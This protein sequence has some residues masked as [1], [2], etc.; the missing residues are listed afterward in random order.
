MSDFNGKH[1]FPLYIKEDD[2]AAV[3]SMYREYGCASQSE[4]IEKAVEFYLGYLKMDMDMDLIAPVVMSTIRSVVTENT[5][6][7]TRLLFK[8]SVEMALMNNILAYEY[9]IDPENVKKVREEC[10]KT[11][12]KTNG[13]FMLEDAINWQRG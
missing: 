13:N 4:F 3:K 8:N 1:R 2:L 5:T 11:V 6:R 10:E 12:R 7:I 9:Q